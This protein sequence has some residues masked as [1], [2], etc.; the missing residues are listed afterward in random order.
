MA[1]LNR[2]R[3]YA[4][5]DPMFSLY[6]NSAA[7]SSKITGKIGGVNQGQVGIGK[8]LTVGR[9]HFTKPCFSPR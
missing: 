9:N 7:I 3:T 6:S 4:L 8:Y 1:A 5:I 2:V